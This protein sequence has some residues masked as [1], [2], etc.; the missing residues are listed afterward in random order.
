M[1]LEK[2]SSGYIASSSAVLAVRENITV[3]NCM[4]LATSDEQYHGII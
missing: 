3:N 1:E 4:N 2:E